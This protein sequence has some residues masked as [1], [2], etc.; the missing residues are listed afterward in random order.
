MKWLSLILI[1][2]VTGFGL[3]FL[4]YSYYQDETDIT[5][6]NVIEYDDYHAAFYQNKEFYGGLEAIETD[7]IIQEKV[8]GGIVSHH[9]LISSEIAKFFLNLKEQNPKTIVI[10]GPNHYGLGSNLFIS[11]YPF[12]TPW[13]LLEPDLDV[14]D[15]LIQAGYVE[16]QEKP[17]EIEHSISSL[18]GFIKYVFPDAK[19]APVIL[20]KKTPKDQ[21]DKLA[22]ELDKILLDETL[23]I[24]SVDFSHHLNR[25]ASNFHDKKSISAINSFDFDNIFNLEIDSPPSIY[26]LLKYLEKRNAFKTSHLVST[27]AADYSGILNMKD[28]T[29]YVFEYFIKGPK[30]DQDNITL[31]NFGDAM[32]DREVKNVINQGINPFEYI[33][34]VEG[35][36]LKGVDYISLNLEGPITNTNQCQKKSYWFKFE[37]EIANLLSRNNI[38]IVNLANNHIF[39]CYEQ[40]IEDTKEYLDALGIDYFGQIDLSNSY[41]IKEVNK[42]KIAFLG[43]DQTMM[44]IAMDYFY[45]LIKQLKEDNNYVV[46][47]IHWGYEYSFSP[48]KTQKQTA[49]NLIDSGADIIIGHHP[50]VVQPV[51]IYNNRAIFYSLGNFIFDMLTRET[52]EGIGVGV[53]LDENNYSFYL[54]PYEII[55][56]QPRLFS[57]D[58]S[59]TFCNQFLK[60]VINFD[61]CSFSLLNN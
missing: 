44:P 58:R 53:V 43:I 52:N 6:N 51:E 47:N 11:K 8:Y 37:P 7:N 34:G 31:L 3:V 29:S 54:F 24:S 4:I 27:N 49:Y 12:K 32:F 57:Y 17:F 60:D 20:S 36:F 55:N 19:I 13:G 22:E 39:D 59:I 14:I 26:V 45:D 21:L 18:V 1:L 30:K 42:K 15:A 38:N 2:L 46:V 41:I 56:F 61:D 48:S 5:A 40:G 10:L 25:M 9:M 50:H 16:N 35:N 33:K 23:V 28:V